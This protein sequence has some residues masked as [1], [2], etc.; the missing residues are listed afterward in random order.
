MENN[1]TRQNKKLPPITGSLKKYEIVCS[2]EN[3]RNIIIHWL[4][5]TGNEWEDFGEM[6]EFMGIKTPVALYELDSEKKTFKCLSIL[7]DATYQLR[8]VNKFENSGQKYDQIWVKKQNVKERYNIL[9]KYP[10]LPKDYRKI[11]LCSKEKFNSLDEV[12]DDFFYSQNSLS[13]KLNLTDGSI[14]DIRIMEPTTSEKKTVHNSKVLSPDVPA[15][16]EKYLYGLDG[17]LDA[18]EVYSKII[19]IIGF[20]REEINHSER[21]CVYHRKSFDDCDIPIGAYCKSRGKLYEYAI[22]NEI[23]EVFYV[24]AEGSWEY[25]YNEKKISYSLIKDKHIS[26]TATEGYPEGFLTDGNEEFARIKKQIEDMIKKL[27]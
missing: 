8:L 17:F 24:S 20:T 26:G 5:R 6:L 19:D 21:I 3:V 25:S 23:G 16:I 1:F 11:Y 14:L 15:K 27:R 22:Q 2:S 10:N 12:I 13:V 9:P 7:A 18:Q 4:T